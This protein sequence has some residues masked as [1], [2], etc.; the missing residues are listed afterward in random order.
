LTW[1]LARVAPDTVATEVDPGSAAFPGHFPGEPV[2][3]GVCLI[4]LVTRAAVE[5]GGGRPP[6]QLAVERARFSAP[7]LPGDRLEV[8]ITASA[9]EIR[10]VVRQARGVACQIR[11]GPPGAVTATPVDP[12]ALLPHRP[13]M[14]LLDEV[15]PVEPGAS[16]VALRSPRAGDPWCGPDGLAAYLVLESW[17]QACVALVRH[18]SGRARKVLVGGLREARVTRAVRLGET[19][20]HHVHL[21]RV[22]DSSAICAG[23]G[24]V[25]GEIVLSVAQATF[26]MARELDT[27]Q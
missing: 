18:S 3:P 25:G 22:L 12:A 16:L 8:M 17:L 5:I 23:T 11:F 1:T 13:P 24:T 26:S 6:P 21:V 9:T 15:L 2:V 7:V 14:L 27:A 10:G 4:D 20:V 19:L